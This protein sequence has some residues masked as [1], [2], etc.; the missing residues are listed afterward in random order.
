MKKTIVCLRIDVEI[1]EGLGVE[2]NKFLLFTPD[3]RKKNKLATRSKW[4]RRAHGYYG[5]DKWLVD[6]VCEAVRGHLEYNIRH[7]ECRKRI[8]AEKLKK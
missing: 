4:Q 2:G 8:L 5:N 3:Q 7:R 1:G 6:A